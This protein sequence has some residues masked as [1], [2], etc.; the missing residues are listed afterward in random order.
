MRKL[1]RSLSK[2]APGGG[3]S[4]SSVKCCWQSPRARVQLCWALICF[5]GAADGRGEN[6]REER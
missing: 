4:R 3:G 2:E 5:K 6:P 1:G